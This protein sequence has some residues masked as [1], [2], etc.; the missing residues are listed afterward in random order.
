[1]GGVENDPKIQSSHVEQ[2]QPDEVKSEKDVK[3]EA[4]GF[5]KVQESKNKAEQQNIF[6]RI[7]KDMSGKTA[8]AAQQQ[9]VRDLFGI[10]SRTK[11]LPKDFSEKVFTHL[12]KGKISAD[13]ALKLVSDF[14]DQM[15]LPKGTLTQLLN[16]DSLNA[17]QVYDFLLPFEDQFQGT[18]SL[19]EGIAYVMLKYMQE[20]RDDTLSL[21]QVKNLMVEFGKLSQSNLE[22]FEDQFADF[23]LEFTEDADLRGIISAQFQRGVEK[24]EEEFESEVTL[25]NFREILKDGDVAKFMDF[26]IGQ[27][28]LEALQSDETVSLK[29]ETLDKLC[30]SEEFANFMTAFAEDA[31][32]T[33][34]S[35]ILSSDNPKEGV[36]KSF[37]DLIQSLIVKTKSGGNVELNDA[38]RA[39]LELINKFDK[40]ANTTEGPKTIGSKI[41]GLFK[42]I[43]KRL[44]IGL[45]SSIS[46]G[47]SFLP[48][49]GASEGSI[50][51]LIIAATGGAAAAPA[52]I[53][54]LSIIGGCFTIGFLMGV[55]GGEKGF[56]KI[57]TFI[58][59]FKKVSVVVLQV[60][61]LFSEL[62]LSKEQKEKG[63]EILNEDLNLQALNDI[64]P[65]DLKNALTILE[66]LGI[67]IEKEVGA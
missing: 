58:E 40:I 60:S 21:G 3:T 2:A 54:A 7:V 17:T 51:G 12:E 45:A 56:A 32:E 64:N 15:T 37:I 67:K 52:G 62:I 30:D 5:P 49:M 41:K 61:S 36:E 34:I 26:M 23:L 46:L 65:K 53:V 59:K 27:R 31:I 14:K 43:S 18:L 1:M 25:E 11:T 22:T 47:L 57:N 42:A 66:E 9:E 13:Q 55:I 48:L 35:S 50:L 4:A 44:G 63:A 19:E 28:S 8:S 10:N 20:N 6:S 33:N 38:E 16:N 39:F 24:A 29:K